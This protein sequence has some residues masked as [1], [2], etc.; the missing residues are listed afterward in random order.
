M[1]LP[2]AVSDAVTLAMLALLLVVAHRHPRPRTE[3]AAGVLAAAVTIAV[4]ALG[5]HQAWDAVRPL[6]SVVGFLAMIVVVAGVCGRA[7]LFHLAARAIEAR[8]TGRPGVLFGGVFALAVVVTTVLSLDATVVLLTP[9]AV[10]AARRLRFS[11][12]PTAYACL[13]LANSGSLLLP[14]SNLTNLLAMPYLHLS[15][16]GFAARMALPL[17][18]VLV[19]EYAG[20]RLLFAADLV[21]PAPP[22]ARRLVDTDPADPA[23][24][25]ST[26]PA[27]PSPAKRV[28]LLVVLAM[29][30][31]FAAGSPLGI[32]PF[33][34]AAAAA[35]T[36][37]WWGRRRGLVTVRGEVRA[38]HPGFLLLVLGLG[39]VVAGLTDGFLG[40]LVG[41]LLPGGTGLWDMLV[42][43]ALASV[44]ATALTNLSATLLL[45]PAVAPLGTDAVLAALVGLTVGAGLTWTGSLA[46]LLWR[47]TLVAGGIEPSQRQFHRVSLTLTPVA[48][49]AATAALWLTT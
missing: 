20:L 16:T 13:R 36:L 22:A 32:E 23:L 42:V 40:D 49:F 6:L 34:P 21:P 28:P 7:G 27:Q 10:L 31:A 43:A 19:V 18:A 29:L 11:P 41:R 44:A 2:S 4:G 3:A 47:R 17:L 38:A 30:A 35:V 14:V 8:A 45:L 24:V 39:V 26:D 9:V 12:R 46:N 1:P 37:V 33:W 15:F 5:P 25:D 48:L